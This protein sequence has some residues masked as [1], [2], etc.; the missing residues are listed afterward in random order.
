MDGAISFSII[1]LIKRKKWNFLCIK[2]Y[3]G[4]YFDYQ[5]VAIRPSCDDG[6]LPHEHKHHK[7]TPIRY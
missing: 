6:T 2:F 3:N 5:G 1:D 7:F 4:R